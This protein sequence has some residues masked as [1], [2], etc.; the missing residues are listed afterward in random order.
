VDGFDTHSHQPATRLIQQ[1]SDAYAF[2]E[3]VEHSGHETHTH[4]TFSEFGRRV[5]ENASQ[6]TDHGAAAPMFIAGTRVRAGLVG[7]HPNL[8]ELE[9]GD[10][11]FHTDFRQVYATL[12]ERWLGWSSKSVLG[13]SFKAI[14][15]LRV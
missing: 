15:T 1:L 8:D 4:V 13:G 9:D 6:G 14:D 12:L 3:D 10:I 5:T 2:V 7:E 11:K